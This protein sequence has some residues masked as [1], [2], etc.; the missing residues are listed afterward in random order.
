M[1]KALV[2]LVTTSLALV[3]SAAAPGSPTRASLRLTDAQ[4]VTLS[5]VRFHPGEGVRVTVA[6]GSVHRS[7]FI[8][9]SRAGV[10]VAR[11]SEVSTDR[12]SGLSAL[13]VGGRGSRATFKLVPLGCPPSP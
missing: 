4:P 3:A 2:L 7:R 1:S 9:A 5:G 6:V 11:F 13:A 10:F 12:C 8:R